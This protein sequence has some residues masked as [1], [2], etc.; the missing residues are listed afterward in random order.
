MH[1]PQFAIAMGPGYSVVAV[2]VV[3]GAACDLLGRLCHA[4]DGH[5]R[6]RYDLP[7]VSR[8]TPKASS[9]LPHGRGY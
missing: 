8:I 2:L 7:A 5:R 4:F 9:P 3:A 1:G 6:C